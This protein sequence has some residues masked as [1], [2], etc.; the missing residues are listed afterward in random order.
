MQADIQPFMHGKPSLTTMRIWIV[1]L[2]AFLLVS[3]AGAE[4][5]VNLTFPDA[6]PRQA[7]IQIGFPSAP[8]ASPSK[9]QGASINLVVPAKDPE[10][11]VFV[12]SQDDLTVATKKLSAIKDGSWDVKPADFDGLAEV[13][14]SIE[15]DGKPVSAASVDLKDGYRSQPQ[16]QILDSSAKGVVS[17]FAIKSGTVSVSVHYRSNGAMAPPITQ[18]FEVKPSKSP[19]VLRI[20]IADAVDTLAATSVGATASPDSSAAGS[21]EPITVKDVPAPDHRAV[22][23]N[24]FGSFLVIV[25]VLGLV[26]A[27]GFYLMQ[28]MK[29]NPEKT[30]STLEQLGVQ[31]PKP[32]DAPLNNAVPNVPMPAPSPPEPVQKIILDPVGAASSMAPQSPISL[33]PI[34]PY[35]PSGPVVNPRLV[36]AS[37]DAIPVSDQGFIVGRDAGLGLSLISEST[38]SRKHAEMQRI[39]DGFIVRDLGSTNGTYINGLRLQGEQAVRPGDEIRFGAVAFRFEG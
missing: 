6:T 20:A 7:W 29:N 37:G 1:S 19:A 30:A 3:F 38:V 39:G 18:S 26:L 31:I 9:V 35:A 32:G 5:S 15:H 12:Q 23:S 2:F 10:S 21:A 27:G 34:Q 14:V 11:R 33:D 4:E 17:F 24:P 13:R 36:A 16:T 22:S 28:Y 25:V 8:P